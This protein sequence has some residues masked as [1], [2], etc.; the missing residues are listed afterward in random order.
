MIRIAIDA[1]GG[2]FAPKEQVKGTILALN[3]DKDFIAVLCGDE[4]TLK[5]ELA[6]YTYDTS[7]VEIVHAPEVITNDDIPTKAV[8][9]KKNSSTVATFRLLKEEKADAAVSGG[10]TG[11]VLTAGVLTLGRIKGVSRPA[12][13]PRIPDLSGRGTLLCDC[14]ANLECKSVNLVHFALMAS[15]YAEAVYGWKNPRTGLLNNGTEDHKGDELHRET[16]EILKTVQGINYVGNVEG[17]DIMLGDVDVVVSDGYTGN[18]ALKSIEGCGKA[19][20]GI[21]KREFKKN[22]FCKLRALLVK[23]VLNKVKKSADYE[24]MGGAVFLGLTKPVVKAH[25][26]SKAYGFSVCIAQ[27]V[28]AV[29]GDLAGRIKTLLEKNVEKEGAGEADTE[30]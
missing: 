6:A 17:R 29:R 11:A 23:D 9:T 16:N 18:I 25:G 15:A 12:L 8:R 22:L 28:N 10:A 20:S 30:Q 4:K 24:T 21:L 3:E 5:A 19:V 26:N 13:C 2:D 7:R 27:A 1:M 14:G